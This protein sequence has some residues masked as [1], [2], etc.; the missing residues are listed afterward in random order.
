MR[1]IREVGFAAEETPDAP[2][3]IANEGPV[4]LALF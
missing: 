3:K 1:I 2:Q 4:H